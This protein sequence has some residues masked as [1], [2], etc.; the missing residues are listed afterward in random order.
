MLRLSGIAPHGNDADRLLVT[1]SLL[2]AIAQLFALTRDREDWLAALDDGFVSWITDSHPGREWAGE[3]HGTVGERDWKRRRRGAI[4]QSLYMDVVSPRE[5]NVFGEYYTPGWLAALRAETSARTSTR[6]EGATGD[7]PRDRSRLFSFVVIAVGS[8]A[9][10]DYFPEF[11]AAAQADVVDVTSNRPPVL[12]T[13]PAP[14]TRRSSRR[15][16]KAPWRGTGTPQSSSG[17][18]W[19]STA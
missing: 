16:R 11:E 12:A 17:R 14:S 5:R 3:L 7:C 18:W 6:L 8:A 19:R 9:E 15:R 10:Q 13:T 1:H 2:I 4:M